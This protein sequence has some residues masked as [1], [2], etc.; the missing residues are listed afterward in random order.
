MNAGVG[1][2]Q[3]GNAVRIILPGTHGFHRRACRIDKQKRQITG[4]ANIERPGIE[5][6]LH[7]RAG[8]KSGELKIVRQIVQF[9]RSFQGGK[10]IAFHIA[11][12]QRDFI[13][14]Q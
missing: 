10:T 14:R 8:V 2:G 12:A 1:A 7:R 9:A 4:K 11:E 3:Q 6:F 5:R 13:G